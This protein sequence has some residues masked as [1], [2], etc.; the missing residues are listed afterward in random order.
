MR[1]TPDRLFDVASAGFSQGQN[2]VT[3]AAQL[4]PDSMVITAIGGALL[5]ETAGRLPKVPS[6]PLGYTELEN[7]YVCDHGIVVNRDGSIVMGERMRAEKW[8]I[9]YLLKRISS[10]RHK[11]VCPTLCDAGCLTVPDGVLLAGEG[12]KCYG[13]WLLDFLPPLRHL[14]Q[15]GLLDDTTL[16]ASSDAPGYTLPMLDRFTGGA[17]TRVMK[18]DRES[19]IVFVEKLIV[20]WRV[21]DH[22]VFHPDANKVFNLMAAENTLPAGKDRIFVSRKRFGGGWSDRECAN[23]DDLT[24]ICLRHGY[25]IVFP[26]EMPFS[27]QIGVFASARVVIGECGSGLHNTLFSPKGTKVLEFGP[28]TYSTP[29]QFAISLLRGHEQIALRGGVLPD[30]RTKMGGRYNINPNKLKAALALIDSAD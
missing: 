9:E 25:Q 14:A 17:A 20:P 13:H 15:T 10:L 7:V 23:L 8:R 21:R 18:F 12:P 16:I 29:M 6:A 27:E 2:V 5:G 19:E 4:V 22:R 26:E 24:D 30:S 1:F 3:R 11:G 28:G